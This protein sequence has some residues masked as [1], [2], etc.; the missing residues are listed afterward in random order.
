MTSEGADGTQNT[1]RRPIKTRGASWAQA[2]SRWLIRV[3]ATPNAVSLFSILAASVG[4]L[5]L[6][7]GHRL[8]GWSGAA[9]YLGVIVCVQI[10]LLCNLFDGLMAV[11]GGMRSATGEL[12]NEIPD[13]VSDTILFV[14]AGAAVGYSWLGWF[15]A[16]L[17]L[18]TAYVRS[19]GASLGLEQDFSGP[20][21]K[22]QRMFFLSVG[23]LWA[24]VELVINDRPIGGFLAVLVLIAAGTLYTCVRRVRRMAIRLGKNDHD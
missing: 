18:T 24:S 21:A 16:A 15:I 11:E 1:I 19:L 17:A 5:L 14:A 12:Y 2:F 6:L 4:A 7:Q 3:G 23:C 20:L 22:P 8:T 10:R 9:C 13:R